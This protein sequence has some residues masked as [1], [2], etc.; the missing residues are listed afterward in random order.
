MT[1]LIVIGGRGSDDK[2]TAQDGRRGSGQVTRHGVRDDDLL[3][4]DSAEHAVA[5]NL[6]A[7]MA[8]DSYAGC[9]GRAGHNVSSDSSTCNVQRLGSRLTRLRRTA[10]EVLRSRSGSARKGARSEATRWHLAWPK[11]P[12]HTDAR[13]GVLFPK[14]RGVPGASSF[15]RSFVAALRRRRQL[16]RDL[17]LRRDVEPVRR[18]AAAAHVLG[19]RVEPVDARVVDVLGRRKGLRGAAARRA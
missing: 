11:R 2:A 4:A 9:R 17:L 6:V 19:G 15:A 7:A 8:A 14:C 18:V 16:A 5:A 3:A 13:R 1:R 12:L 10:I